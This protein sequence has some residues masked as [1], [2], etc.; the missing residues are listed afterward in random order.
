LIN[1]IDSTTIS[2]PLQW[3][4]ARPHEGFDRIIKTIMPSLDILMA[5]QIK[6]MEK[7]L[8]RAQKIYES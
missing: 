2:R 3:E 5:R 6:E 7:D 4:V 1:N 8:K